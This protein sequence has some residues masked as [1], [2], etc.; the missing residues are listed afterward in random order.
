MLATRC[1][2]LAVDAGARRRMVVGPAVAAYQSCL[3]R[4]IK[5]PNHP[6]PSGGGAE[7]DNTVFAVMQSLQGQPRACELGVSSVTA[8]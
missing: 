4:Q 2:A 5:R 7:L 6:V 8:C 3:R 1:S